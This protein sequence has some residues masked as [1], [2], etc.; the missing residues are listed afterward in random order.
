LREYLL[1]WE[2]PEPFVHGGE[3]IALF[4]LR[5]HAGGAYRVGGRIIE[6]DAASTNQGSL[7]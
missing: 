1:W 3:P 2:G 7:A 5:E 6:G 4:G